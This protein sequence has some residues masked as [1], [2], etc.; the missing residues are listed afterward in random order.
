MLSSELLPHL[1]MS[2][3]TPSAPAM[4]PTLGFYKLKMPSGN[5]GGLSEL[6]CVW[7]CLVVLGLLDL[8]PPDPKLP[9]K[10]MG[11]EQ[12]SR[13]A[14][15]DVGCPNRLVWFLSLCFDL[16]SEELDV[17]ERPQMT[18]KTMCS[19][20]LLMLGGRVSLRALEQG[21]HG[22]SYVLV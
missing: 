10:Y 9:W 19:L 6:R 13:Q 22:A 21:T 11:K 12:K 8:L 4:E 14:G 2:C 18:S 7:Q 3:K 15:G 5:P 20:H 17:S 16:F 1:F